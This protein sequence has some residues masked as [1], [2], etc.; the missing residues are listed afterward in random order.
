VTILKSRPRKILFVQRSGGGGS[1]INVLLLVKYLDHDRF[2]PTV[3]FFDS[4]PYED[5]FR[6]AGAEVRVME[7]STTDRST[8]KRSASPPTNGMKRK[9]F[10][11]ARRLKRVVL[12]DWPMARRIAQVI[13]AVGADL[14]QSSI[15]PSADRSSILAA[16]LARVRQ[17]SYSQFFSADEPWLDRPI[18]TLVDRY[19]CISE[20]VRSHVLDASG[21]CEDKTRLVYAPF[22]FP[23]STTTPAASAVR[24][25]LGANGRHRLIANVG[26]I[27]PWKGQDV[28]LRAFAS[29]VRSH[30][31]ARAVVVGSPGENQRGQ[32]FEAELHRLATELGL[33]ER[34]IFTGHRNDVDDI[35]A[36]SDVVVHSSSQPE[37]LGR[38]V[39]EAIALRKPV[40]ATGAGGVPEM[41]RDGRT[42]SLVP[43]GDAESMAGAL[44]SVLRDPVRASQMA[45]RAREEAEHRFAAGTF[46]RTMENEYCRILGD[47]RGG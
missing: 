9:G 32:E 28:F 42:G 26:R 12:R 7:N 16:G 38:V 30:P 34:V 23:I 15:C 14:V 3:L 17:V 40:I 29:I 35:M 22:E 31:E 4:S 6:A 47:R 24:A 8:S 11:R 21:V 44:D 2:K 5:E 37:P 25:G 1:L 27:V 19:L 18:S 10:R 33:N 39:M 45:V 13:E 43:P 36:A 41:V 20:S 46:V